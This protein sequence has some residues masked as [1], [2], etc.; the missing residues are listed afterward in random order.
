MLKNIEIL[1]DQQ[2]D[3]SLPRGKSIVVKDAIV[4]EAEEKRAK[5]GRPTNMALFLADK[6]RLRRAKGWYPEE[7]KIEVAALFAA[8]VSNSKE[9]ERL[10]GVKDTAI[11][12]WKTE[13]WWPEMLERI[14]VAH[15]QE[16]VS[17]FTKIIDNSLEQIQDRLINGDYIYDKKSGEIIRKPVSLKDATSTA[18]VIVDKRQ[19]LRGKPTSRSES[20]GTAERLKKLADEF[21]KFSEAKTIQGEVIR[22][23]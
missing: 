2:I 15:D 17:K 12:K 10:T 16:T 4:A 14:H 19:L 22:E 9:L 11:R 1:E 7:K 3:P 23:S 21:K 8:G 13:D 20:V 5:G 18:S 6:S